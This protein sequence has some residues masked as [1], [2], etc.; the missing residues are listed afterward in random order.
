MGIQ[1]SLVNTVSQAFPGLCAFVTSSTNYFVLLVMN[2]QSPRN[3]AKY[4]PHG[5]MKDGEQFV[6]PSDI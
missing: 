1:Y 4:S 3:K 2:T 6:W 5:K